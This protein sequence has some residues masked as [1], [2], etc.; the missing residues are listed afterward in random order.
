MPTKLAKIIHANKTCGDN[1]PYPFLSLV[2]YLHFVWAVQVYVRPE[3][4]LGI[5]NRQALIV[6][7]KQLC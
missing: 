6:G 1:S 2:L 3:K 7:I 4:K 5:K